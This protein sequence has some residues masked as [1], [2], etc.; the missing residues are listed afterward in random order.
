MLSQFCTAI[1]LR[2]GN[3]VT[4]RLLLSA[5]REMPSQISPLPLPNAASERTPPV[6]GRLSDEQDFAETDKD[7]ESFKLLLVDDN[8]DL[9]EMTSELLWESGFE[10]F[11]AASGKEAL[12]MLE[13]NPNIDAVLTDVVMPDMNG[14]E[15]GHEVRKRYPSIT[16]ILASGYPNPAT[17][18]HGNV[19]DFPFLKKPYRIDQ[20]IR[21]LLK[22]N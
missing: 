21:L 22:P 16:V 6:E 15:L 5:P 9:L 12:Q 18:G 11:I 14:L 7:A 8:A 1:K 3:S 13:Q 4:V 10:A 20:V 19:H 2:R 17:V